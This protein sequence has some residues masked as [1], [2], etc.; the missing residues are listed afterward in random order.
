MEIDTT[1][2][3]GEPRTFRVRG[4]V[5]YENGNPVSHIRIAAF[6][7]DLQS[8]QLLGEAVTDDRGTYT[9]EYSANF[10]QE[11]DRGVVDLVVRAYDV[12]HTIVA[13][14]PV[15][16]RAREDETIDLTIEREQ[17]R[18]RPMFLWLIDRLRG[19]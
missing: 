18:L 5:Q 6:D 17:G 8:E 10:P 15:R 1:R 16:F 12:H 9:I 2:E 3:R 7:K 14:S 11:R 19:V 4:R 13:E